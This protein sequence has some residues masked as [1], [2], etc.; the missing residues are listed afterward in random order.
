MVRAVA[1]EMP[2]R[3]RFARGLAYR[4]GQPAFEPYVKLEPWVRRAVPAMIAVFIGTLTTLTILLMSD[5]HD[6]AIDDAIVDLELIAATATHDFNTALEPIA[7]KVTAPEPIASKDT[8]QEAKQALAQVLPDRALARG[9]HILIS[10]AQGEIVAAYP[11]A[12]G[13]GGRLID[14]LGPSQPLTVF[15]EKAG[16]MRVNLA[17]GTAALATVRTLKPPFAQVA[18]IHPMT[19]VLADWR[20]A[21]FR[22]GAALLSTIIVL[23]SV[24]G[25]YFWQAARA[26]HAEADGNRIRGR[27]DTALN[28]GRCGLWDWDLA[29]GRIYWSDSMYAM[30]GM[31]PD[32]SFLSFGDVDALIHPQDDTLTCL[33]ELLAAAETNAIDHTFRIRNA[34]GEWVWLRARAEL[35]CDRADQAAHLVGIAVDITE[36]KL[37]AEQSATADIRLRDALETV[38]EAFVLWDKDNRLVMCNSKFQRFHNLPN[39]AILAG[40]PYAQVMT[41]GAAPMIQ[42]EIAIDHDDIGSNRSDVMNVIDSKR[43]ERDAS[44]KPVPTFPHP[45]PGQRPQAGARTYEARLADGRWLQ[46]NERRT[47]DGGY[48]SVGTDIT[49]LK[50]H[51][52][53]LMDS[54]RRL[55]ATVADLRRSRQTLEL[56]AQQLA[57]LAE[58]YLEQ[59]AEAESANRAKSE[60]LANMSHELR[61]PLNAIIGFSELMTQETF[62]AL[63]SPRYIDYCNDIQASGQRLLTV[64]SDVLDMSRLDAGRVR[65]EKS[66]FFIDAAIDKAL[67]GVRAWAAEK[68]IAIVA[69]NL[70]QSKIHA[71]RLAIERILAILLRNAVKFTREK[72]RIAVRCR[73][74]PGATNIYVED[75]G[76]GISAEALVQLGHPFEQCNSRLENGFKGSGLGLAIARSLVDLHGGSLRIRSTLGKG[77]IVLVHLPK[78]QT[79]IAEALPRPKPLRALGPLRHPPRPALRSVGGTQAH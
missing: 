37:L 66:E 74:A 52:E 18:F 40:S 32:E 33:A 3:A 75:S 2:A 61:T 12:I 67:D 14:H 29:R 73:S 53:Q 34:K 49:A 63:G 55:M 27:I 56:Q 8:A 39:E 5:A 25:A 4:A 22:T 57:E 31:V 1:A 79:P 51:E 46:I 16:V 36:Q 47:K 9:Q 11:P 62:G 68:S 17:D 26:R 21:A 69:A 72:G 70:P 23:C 42:S 38:S 13:I 64:I 50:H 71:D 77:T 60:F 54:E 65:L 35:V 41:S 45:A 10:N 30:L 59:K 6:R 44:G 43:L 76:I 19:S 58:K 48:V 28:R 15:A 20:R 24:A 78:G 7:G